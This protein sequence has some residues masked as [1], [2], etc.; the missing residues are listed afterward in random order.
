[1]MKVTCVTSSTLV[2][3]EQL[4]SNAEH[5]VLQGVLSK[6]LST[7]HKALVGILALLGVISFFLRGS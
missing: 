2:F 3:Q 1:M 7:R 4:P 5:S 6:R